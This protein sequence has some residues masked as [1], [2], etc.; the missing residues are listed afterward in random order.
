MPVAPEAFPV[1]GACCRNSH[2][3]AGWRVIEETLSVR[4]HHCAC[5]GWAVGPPAA[6]VGAGG[7]CGP[8]CAQGQEYSFFHAQRV[9]T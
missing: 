6:L 3:R 8:E 9:A 5:N 4:K 1:M 7:T 2:E